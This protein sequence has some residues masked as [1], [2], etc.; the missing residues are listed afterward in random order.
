MRALRFMYLFQVSAF[1]PSFMVL[2][3]QTQCLQ[4]CLCVFFTAQTVTAIGDSDSQLG[5][6]FYNGF[7]VLGR[8]IVKLKPKLLYISN[9]TS[10]S[11]LWTRN[12]IFWASRVY[13]L[14]SLINDVGHQDMT[15][16]S[17]AH[18]VVDASGFLAVPQNFDISIWLVPDELL[19]LLFDDLWLYERS[20]GSHDAK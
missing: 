14:V 1:S 15:H 17:P 7:A 11:V 20:D 13:F 2:L 9:T 10:S 16:E 5:F 8:N 4:S 3:T 18:P 6:S 12:W 19:G